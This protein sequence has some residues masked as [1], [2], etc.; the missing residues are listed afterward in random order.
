MFC[1]LMRRNF[2][3]ILYKKRSRNGIFQIYYLLFRM[4]NWFCGSFAGNKFI[5]IKI[6]CDKI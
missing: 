3:N 1:F 2:Q 4:P 6:C 5:N